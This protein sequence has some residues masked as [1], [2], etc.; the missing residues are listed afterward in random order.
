MRPRPLGPPVEL[1]MGR[2]T[3]EGCADMGV[4]SNTPAPTWAVGGAPYGAA[5]KRVRGVPKWAW[6]VM[7][8]C[9]LGPSVELLMGHGT[10]EGCAEM[11]VVSN[12]PAAIGAL[13]GAPHGATRRVRGVPTWAWS[14]MRVRSRPLRP[15][16]ERPMAPRNA[17]G[18]CRSGRGQ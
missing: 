16:V 1:P 3:C 7:R 10:R 12:T 15:S 11:G 6:S 5:K 2:E 13:G 14:V 17:R 9:P 8:A 18:V 4:V